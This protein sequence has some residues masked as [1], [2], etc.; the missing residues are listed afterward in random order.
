MAYCIRAYRPL[1][2]DKNFRILRLWFN[3]IF[4]IFSPKSLKKWTFVAKNWRFIQILLKWQYNQDRRGYG[5][6]SAYF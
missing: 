4:F 1:A 6:T 2:V 5:I 3:E